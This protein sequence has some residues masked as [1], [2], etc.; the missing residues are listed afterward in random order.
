MSDRRSESKDIE[1]IFVSSN[2]TP[3]SSSH[4]VI[5]R[6]NDTCVH[7]WR[8]D[9]SSSSKPPFLRT[10]FRQNSNNHVRS[11]PE[12]SQRVQQLLLRTIPSRACQMS[13][14]REPTSDH[15]ISVPWY[16]YARP[17]SVAHHVSVCQQTGYLTGTGV[18]FF[19]F[20]GRIDPSDGATVE[21]TRFRQMHAIQRSRYLQTSIKRSAKKSFL[22]AAVVVFVRNNTR[23]LI[24]R[25]ITRHGDGNFFPRVSIELAKNHH[26]R[27]CIIVTFDIVHTHIRI[28]LS[29]LLFSLPVP[30]SI[31]PIAT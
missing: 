18:R 1:K 15:K 26:C 17:C 9:F 4:S 27:F 10:S 20:R 12:I 22:S 8:N 11:M 19:R 21:R 3:S 16:N 13:T 6:R 29:F 28:H 25:C 14:L 2:Q 24:P 7:R 23:T 30:F 5:N 31:L